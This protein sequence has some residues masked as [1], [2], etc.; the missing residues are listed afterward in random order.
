LGAL[1]WGGAA[2]ANA[3]EELVR[4][5]LQPGYIT[6]DFL[7]PP[8][9]VSSTTGFNL[10]FATRFTTGLPWLV[11]VVGG[12]VTPYGTTGPSARNHNSPSLFAGN[13]FPLVAPLRTG[14]WLT[15]ELPLLLYHSYGGGRRD[16]PR[17]FGPDIFLQLAVYV[18]V[19]EKLLGELGPGWRCLDGYFFLEQNMTPNPE[20]S[21]LRLD[22]FNPVALF[23][24]SLKIAGRTGSKGSALK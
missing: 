11:P 14:G 8:P 6:A 9:G 17:L 4:F 3:Q 1:L 16:N 15:A 21:T 24:L 20:P 18:H 7:S 19:G 5:D 12:S 23:G 22:R 13:I 2:P 10:R